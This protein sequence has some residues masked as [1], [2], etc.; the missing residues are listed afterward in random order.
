MSPRGGRSRPRGG[1]NRSK[2][3]F[4]QTREKNIKKVIEKSLGPK[5]AMHFVHQKSPKRRPREEEK[6]TEY[7]IWAV[8]FKK[9]DFSKTY[10]LLK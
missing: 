5:R 1:Q 7:Y 8:L 3:A 2:N 9:C 10:V 6:E 4:E